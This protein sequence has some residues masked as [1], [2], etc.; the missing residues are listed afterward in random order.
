[1]TAVVHCCCQ[2]VHC[3]RLQRLKSSLAGSLELLSTR[4][5]VRC[6]NIVTHLLLCRHTSDNSTQPTSV[7]NLRIGS[8][9]QPRRLMRHCVRGFPRQRIER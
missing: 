8:A 2:T 9:G 1:M 6:F 5:R 7:A 3:R 4:T